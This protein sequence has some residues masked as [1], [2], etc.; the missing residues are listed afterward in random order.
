MQQ[1]LL[2]DGWSPTSLNN[3]IILFNFH[4]KYIQVSPGPMNLPSPLHLAHL[5][6]E[7]VSCLQQLYTHT[8]EFPAVQ[9]VSV[10]VG[11]SIFFFQNLAEKNTVQHKILAGENF[12]EQ[13]AKL[14]WAKKTWA[15]LSP[16]SSFF[17]NATSNWRIKFWLIHSESPKFSPTKVFRYTVLIDNTYGLSSVLSTDTFGFNC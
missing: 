5:P 12:G 1:Q 16:A 13:Q 15:N 4:A 17:S 3:R 6:A 2:S 14:H 7:S 11:C 8:M 10:K 9:R